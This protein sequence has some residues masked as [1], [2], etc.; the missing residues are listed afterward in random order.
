[1]SGGGGEAF[2]LAGFSFFTSRPTLP[3]AAHPVWSRGRGVTVKKEAHMPNCTRTSE[4]SQH[5]STVLPRQQAAR[6]ALAVEL[7]LLGLCAVYGI[8]A[9]GGSHAESSSFCQQ[10]GGVQ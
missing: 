7:A 8:A 1:M 3:F 6:F 9:T 5:Q 2:G 10:A 4:Q